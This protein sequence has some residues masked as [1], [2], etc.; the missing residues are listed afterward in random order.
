MTATRQHAIDKGLAD[1]KRAIALPIWAHGTKVG[2]LT[3][4]QASDLDAI[5]QEWF[6]AQATKPS[7][8]KTDENH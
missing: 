2:L 8:E 4:E 3:R 1:L 5:I 6:A 7:Q